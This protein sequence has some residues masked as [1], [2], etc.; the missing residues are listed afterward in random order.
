VNASEVQ[1]WLRQRIAARLRLPPE[2]ICLTTPF[3]EFG[4]GSLDAVELAADL[5]RWLGR[6]LSPTA[7]YNHPNIALLTRW[8]AEPPCEP[9]TSDIRHSL[10]P[11]VELNP[12]R[13]LCDVQQL[14]EAEMEA[15][16]TQEL[17]NRKDAQSTRRKQRGVPD[18]DLSRR[19]KVGQTSC[20][21]F[22]A[23]RLEAYPTGR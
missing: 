19:R 6:P 8:L 16:L 2:H 10:P 9:T 4:L 14:S 11:A 13:L 22:L 18:A 7:I 20:L 3:L 15:F 1:S 23:D 5:E 17:A 21:S 12:D